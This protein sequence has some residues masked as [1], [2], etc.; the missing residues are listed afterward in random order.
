MYPDSKRFIWDWHGAGSLSP[1][2]DTAQW[3]H[4]GQDTE[5]LEAKA[6][7][8][9]LPFMVPQTTVVADF[10]QYRWEETQT[11]TQPVWTEAPRRETLRGHFRTQQK[12]PGQVNTGRWKCFLIDHTGK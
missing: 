7:L 11:K 10:K 2:L 3:S 6:G 12:R 9:P 5:E 1:S 8:L 4:W